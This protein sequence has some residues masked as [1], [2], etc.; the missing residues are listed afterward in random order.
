MQADVD[1]LML[2][3]ILRIA[4]REVHRKRDENALMLGMTSVQADAL[5]FVISNP[6]CRI[7]D[8]C[9]QMRTSHQ[10][11]CGIVDRLREKGLIEVSVSREDARVRTITVTSEGYGLYS[12]FMEMG[13]E[14][15][16]A[17]MSELTDTELSE[18][19]AILLK[20]L[21]KDTRNRF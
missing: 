20:I 10:A 8:L 21:G 13:R 16:K 18:L 12:K 4:G 5:T 1:I 9:E 14:S 11:A 19:Y 6:G 7:A 17:L 3:R 2:S 15:N